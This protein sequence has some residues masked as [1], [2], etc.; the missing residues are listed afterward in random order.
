MKRELVVVSFA[1]LALAF[2][3][4]SVLFLRYNSTTVFN[5]VQETAN[6]IITKGEKKNFSNQ[7]FIPEKV[8][9]NTLNKCGI[10]A[11]ADLSAMTVVS[12]PDPSNVNIERVTLQ[13]IKDSDEKVGSFDVICIDFE[14]SFEQ[15]LVTLNN[16]NKQDPNIIKNFFGSP[17]EEVLKLDKKDL[18]RNF[19]VKRSQTKEC[20]ETQGL[21]NYRFLQSK[22]EAKLDD[23]YIECVYNQ[24]DQQGN[25]ARIVNVDFLFDKNSKF[26]IQLGNADAEK[27]FDK[28]LL[29]PN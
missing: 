16:A 19:L 8:S 11:K 12:K 5:K 4:S 2:F 21:K 28:L 18:Y 10:E 3:I 13:E 15:L 26:M 27:I 23:K 1:L 25:L 9:L 14:K 29:I 20:K 6:M 22:V 7:T 17:L 24:K